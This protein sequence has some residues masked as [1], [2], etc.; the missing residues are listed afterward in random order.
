M[1]RAE[2]LLENA[3]KINP[4]LGEAHLQ[5]GIL[6]SERGDSGRAIRAYKQAIEVDPR[7]G[8]AHYRLSQTYK[9]I[10]DDVKARQELEAYK[11]VQKTDAAAIEQKRK[12]LQQFLVILGDQPVGARSH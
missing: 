3:V 6:Y 1:K 11:Q 10:G 5:L 4:R 12:E 9:Q 7:L 8:E 2:G